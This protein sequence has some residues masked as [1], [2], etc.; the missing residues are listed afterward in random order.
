MIYGGYGLGVVCADGQIGFCKKYKQQTKSDPE[1]GSVNF[2]G[3]SYGIIDN[4]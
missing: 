3:V 1:G 4:C 2:E